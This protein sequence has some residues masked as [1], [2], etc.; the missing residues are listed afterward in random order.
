MPTAGL[1]TA[2]NKCEIAVATVLI[3]SCGGVV[4]G[5]FV[6]GGFVTGAAVPAGAAACV[7]AGAFMRDAGWGVSVAVGVAVFGAT[8][9]RGASGRVAVLGADDS[10]E[11]R[12]V[13]F[14]FFGVVAVACLLL[15]EAAC[16]RFCSSCVSPVRVREA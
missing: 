10:V 1:F 12:P 14:F 16:T 8:S 13:V 3:G 15:P 2:A 4:V 9:A 6:I 5:V 11:G 7:G